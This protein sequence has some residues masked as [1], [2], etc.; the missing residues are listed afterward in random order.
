MA[1]WALTKGSALPREG[2]KIDCCVARDAVLGTCDAKDGHLER[3]AF[4]KYWPIWEV[5]TVP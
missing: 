2:E 1:T 4:P 5:L 3:G